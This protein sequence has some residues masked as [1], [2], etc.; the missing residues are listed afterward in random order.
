MMVKDVTKQVRVIL[1]RHW[2]PIGVVDEPAAQDEYDSYA[3]GVT[4]LVLANATTETI[5]RHL[6]SIER[7]QM[8]L[9]GDEPTARQAAVLLAALRQ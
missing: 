5:M 8:G 3:P 7:E 4:R 6:I 9:P 2:D 1:L